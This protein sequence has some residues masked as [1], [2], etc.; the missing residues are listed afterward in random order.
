[1]GSPVGS[2]GT[3]ADHSPAVQKSFPE[4]RLDAL[5]VQPAKIRDDYG[6]LVTSATTGRHTLFRVPAGGM[7]TTASHG[8]IG[9]ARA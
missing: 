1:M 9:P 8:R 5:D 7:T 6:S 4:R 2:A 3:P